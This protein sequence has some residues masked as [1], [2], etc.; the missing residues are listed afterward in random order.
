MT[1]PGHETYSG[2]CLFGPKSGSY[3]STN[4]PFYRAAKP[5]PL[6]RIAAY[7]AEDIAAAYAQ[8]FEVVTYVHHPLNIKDGRSH[9]ETG[10]WVPQEMSIVDA[11]LG[12]FKAL[13]DAAKTA[14]ECAKIAEKV[15]ATAEDHRGVG[16]ATRNFDAARSELVI[17]KT[18]LGIAGTIRARF[19][20]WK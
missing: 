12:L 3:I 17:A 15:A 2:Y 20:A 18:A 10:V 14:D 16:N 9:L 7:E 11:M 13:G 6:E 5:T 8:S 4:A 1:P 19:G